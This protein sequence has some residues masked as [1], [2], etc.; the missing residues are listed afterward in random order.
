[1]PVDVGSH[2]LMFAGPFVP[3]IHLD[4][5]PQE[6]LY[7]LKLQVSLPTTLEDFVRRQVPGA[8][9]LELCHD[10]RQV[11]LRRGWQ[12]LGPG[13]RAEAG[14]EVFALD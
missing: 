11:V 8:Q 4:D 7:A 9:R 14:D 1:M 10:G 5:H 6:D 2:A 3:W 13:C 12:P